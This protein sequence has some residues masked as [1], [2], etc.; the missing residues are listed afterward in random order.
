[1]AVAVGLILLSLNV[2][3]LYLIYRELKEGIIY[4]IAT[5]VRDV[6]VNLTAIV[7]LLEKIY[8]ELRQTREQV[9]KLRGEDIG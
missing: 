2:L 3:L 8:E 6:K 4:M 5:F 1:M 7:K 9:H